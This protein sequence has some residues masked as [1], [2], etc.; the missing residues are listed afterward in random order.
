MTNEQSLATESLNSLMNQSITESESE[1]Y[2]TTDG[3][4]A[5]LSWNKTPIWGLLPG[6][7]YS[8]TVA[9]LLILDAL[10]DERKGLSFTIAVDPRQHSYSPVRVLW[11]SRPYFTVSDSRLH[12]SSPPTTRRAMVEI[13]DPASIRDSTNHSLMQY[14]L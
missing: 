4:W 7:Y 13:F 8:Q 9:G 12:F 10:F 11:D 2:V 3:Q 5:R 6:I 1:S 14:V